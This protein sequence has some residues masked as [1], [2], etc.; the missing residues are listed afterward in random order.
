[1]TYMRTWEGWLYLAAVQDAYSRRIVGWQMADHMRA[2]LVLDALKMAIERRRP[3]PG[4][5]HHSD[6]GSQL[7]GPGSRRNSVLQ[8]VGEV[9]SVVLDQA[10]QVV[11]V[12]I[13]LKPSPARCEYTLQGLLD[14]LLG[15]EARDVIG[16]VIAVCERAQSRFVASSPANP[17]PRQLWSCR[18]RSRCRTFL[19]W[20]RVYGST[21][22]CASSTSLQIGRAMG[23]S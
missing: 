23:C 9:Q 19:A 14:C 13:A 15:E 1:M 18:P 4:L 2:E 21:I 22:R 5:I 20:V 7:D 10:A 17:G 12:M 16:D 6:Q 11:D 3:E 8:V